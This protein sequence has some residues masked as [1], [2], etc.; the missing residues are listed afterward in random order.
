M[1][2]GLG[3]G[4]YQISVLSWTKQVGSSMRYIVRINIFLVCFAFIAGQA[5]AEISDIIRKSDGTPYFAGDL[6][7]SGYCNKHGMRL[8]TALEY[9]NFARA[10]GASG[11]RDTK[12]PNLNYKDSNVQQE[13]ES[14]SKD[15]FKAIYRSE[16]APKGEILPTAFVSFYYNYSGFQNSSINSGSYKFWTSSDLKVLFH[17]YV[18][19]FDGRDGSISNDDPDL[20]GQIA[21]RCFSN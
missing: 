11:I 3:N 21:F 1:L 20:V 4:H 12:F 18:Y 6:E 13:I 7:A 14:N 2:K 16:P 15:G 10:N 9:A 5:R 8:P 19:Y 17:D